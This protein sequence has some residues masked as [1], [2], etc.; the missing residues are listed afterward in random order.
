MPL[1]I[2]YNVTR[3]AG[4]FF[5]GGVAPTVAAAGGYIQG[6][7][8]SSMSPAFGLASDNALGDDLCSRCTRYGYLLT[9]YRVQSRYCEWR[10]RYCK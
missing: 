1:N 9:Y 7:G 5:V 8:H 6:G 4:K 3:D 2:L 10:P